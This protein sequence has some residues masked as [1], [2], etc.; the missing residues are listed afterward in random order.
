VFFTSSIHTVG[1]ELLNVACAVV[2]S[3]DGGAGFFLLGTRSFYVHCS[4]QRG[5]LDCGLFGIT[6]IFPLSLL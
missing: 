6:D 2:H 5:I 4:V 3:I 1:V